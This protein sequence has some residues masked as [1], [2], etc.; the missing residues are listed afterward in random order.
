[1]IS[2]RLA[3]GF[4]SFGDIDGVGRGR[5]EKGYAC[6][7]EKQDDREESFGQRHILATSY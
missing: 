7:K 3:V 1:M 2:N 6:K 5:A 4:D